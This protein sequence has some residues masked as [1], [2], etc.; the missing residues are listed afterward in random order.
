MTCTAKCR[1][2]ECATPGQAIE[3]VITQ[4][5]GEQMTA[6][7]ADADV[8]GEIVGVDV[9]VHVTLGDRLVDLRPEGVHRVPMVT[10]LGSRF[11]CGL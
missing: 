5:V 7:Y 1:A 4:G 9:T 2:A 11:R 6:Q 8:L 10:S 3:Q